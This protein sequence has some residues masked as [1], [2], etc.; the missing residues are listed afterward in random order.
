MYLTYKYCDILVSYMTESIKAQEDRIR[1]LLQ[2]HLHRTINKEHE[3]FVD[4]LKIMEAQ[5]QWV[6][7]LETIHA[8]RVTRSR[9]NK[10]LI[11]QVRSGKATRWC[12]VSW[13]KGGARKRKEQDPLQ[14][15]FRHA[16]HRQIRQWRDVNKNGRCAQCDDQD[17]LHL[18]LQVDH[19]EPQFLELTKAFLALPINQEP[20]T[21]FAYHHRA[22][23]KFEKKDNRFKTRW[24]NYHRKNAVLQWL[25]RSCNLKKAKST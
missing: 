13:R 19:K 6:D 7:K 17:H 5:P 22:G 25:C 12:T 14:S 11:L 23:R 15:A 18:K 9:L 4:I 20:P 21:K 8:F 24:Q 3:A 10:A 2:Q 16:V 1:E